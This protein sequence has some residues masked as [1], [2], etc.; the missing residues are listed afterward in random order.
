MNVEHAIGTFYYHAFN[1]WNRT[2]YTFPTLILKLYVL[3]ELFPFKTDK[4]ALFHIKFNEN[5]VFL[6]N[7]LLKSLMLGLAIQLSYDHCLY[8]CTMQVEGTST[9][10]PPNVDK[11]NAV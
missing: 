11:T 3:Q 10:S 4:M 2:I 7:N 6:P 8:V 9:K 1:S 5:N